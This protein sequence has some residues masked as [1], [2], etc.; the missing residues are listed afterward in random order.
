MDES[1]NVYEFTYSELIL[2]SRFI[3]VVGV[4]DFG[5]QVSAYRFFQLFGNSVYYREYAGYS[6]FQLLTPEMEKFIRSNDYYIVSGRDMLGSS[7][8]IM[9]Y[10]VRALVTDKGNLIS[11]LPKPDKSIVLG[12]FCRALCAGS[13]N[14]GFYSGEETYILDDRIV[15]VDKDFAV[16]LTPH[17]S[18]DLRGI[19]DMRLRNQVLDI[20]S[21]NSLVTKV[22]K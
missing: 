7:D 8:L 22:V 2:L 18:I 4:S 19:H 12:E 13:L 14:G 5:V 11:V 20:L 3:R 6:N 15:A 16:Y 21:K 10:G 17:S 1:F 9:R